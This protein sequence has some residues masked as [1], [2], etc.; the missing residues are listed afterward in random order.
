MSKKIYKKSF[1]FKKSKKTIDKI[2]FYC[3][4]Q[5]VLSIKTQVPARVAELVDAQDLKSCEYKNSCR[6]KS[7]LG[8][9]KIIYL[10]GD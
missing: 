4:T 7:G 8:H 9:H 1:F 2:W 3:Y 5:I 10:S 6:F